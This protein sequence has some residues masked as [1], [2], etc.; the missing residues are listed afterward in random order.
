MLSLYWNMTGSELRP[1]PKDC[2]VPA[3]VRQPLLRGLGAN[4]AD[5]F[6]SMG[7]LIDAMQADPAVK[8]RR[9]LST[10]GAIAVV[11]SATLA[12]GQL[13]RAR[14]AAS[15]R[16]IAAHVA[17]SDRA[18]AAAR[19]NADVARERRDQAFAAFDLLEAKRGESL[20]RD[21]LA[22]LPKIDAGYEE[23]EQAIAPVLLL[24]PSRRA[25]R[26]RLA[27]IHYEH[28]L[29]ADELHMQSRL[30][31]LRERAASA[32]VNGER[33]KLL[34]APGTLDVATSPPAASIV[35]E[36]LEPDKLT[37]RRNATPVGRFGSAVATSVA[38]RLYRLTIDGPGS[39]ARP[40]PAH[41]RAR[42]ACRRHA[43][44]AGQHRGPAG[45]RLRRSGRAAGSA[46]ATSCCA[47]SSCRPSPFTAARP[48]PI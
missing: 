24:D 6:P 13:V 38:I 16:E 36:R 43:A 42:P 25:T 4:A 32:D 29:F 19:T 26:A 27:D 23:A 21:V 17:A 34:A 41:D 39:G 46:T 15:E 2:R 18:V 47:R 35:I 33:M 12:V 1:V 30:D 10:A 37:G 48:A 20:W 40:V 14:Q 9:L 11:V 7:A 5:R 22:L 8:R 44:L 31:V 28:L 3:W 45:V